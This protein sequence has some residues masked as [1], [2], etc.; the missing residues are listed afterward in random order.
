MI[1]IHGH[2]GVGGKG[3]ILSGIGVVGAQF[4][5]RH[6]TFAKFLCSIG[7]LCIH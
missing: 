6:C 4:L 3:L 2:V 5:K 1:T 7:E